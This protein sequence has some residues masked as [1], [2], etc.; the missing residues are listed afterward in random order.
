MVTCILL[1]VWPLLLKRAPV[2]FDWLLVFTYLY[3]LRILGTFLLGLNYLKGEFGPNKLVFN[4]R[5]PLILIKIKATF[6]S[7]SPL[8]L[9]T[10]S[11]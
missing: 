9:E 11:T 7:R 4:I 10:K 5:W 8:G 6:Q 1:T 3:G 2:T